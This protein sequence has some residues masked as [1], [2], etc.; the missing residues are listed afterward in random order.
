MYSHSCDVYLCIICKLKGAVEVLSD[1]VF[2]LPKPF[3]N[4]EACNKC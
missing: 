1:T 2:I 3:T 4:Y